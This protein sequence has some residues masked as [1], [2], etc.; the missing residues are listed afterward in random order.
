MMMKQNHTL[1]GDCVSIDQ[2]QSTTPGRHKQTRGKEKEK[3][4]GGTIF[5][6][7]ATTFTYAEHQITLSAGNTV[8]SKQNFEAELE[9]YGVIAR[10][11]RADNAPFRS[12]EFLEDIETKRQKISYSGV[13]AHHQNGIAEN[14]IGTI[15]SWARSMMIHAVLHW[16]SQA[17]VELWPMALDF[18]VYVWNHMPKKDGGLSPIELLSGQ[19]EP[20]YDHL[21]RLHTFMAPCYVLDPKLQD[22]KK[23]P[24]W[25]RR[26][27]LG[28]Y[29]GPS[30]DH[31][32]TVGQV[33]NLTT[34]NISPQ[35]HVVHDDGFTTVANP[36][37][38]N[39][40]TLQKVWLELIKS[41]H[42]KYFDPDDLIDAN[43]KLIPPPPLHDQWLTERE[44]RRRML[45]C[46]D[47]VSKSTTFR[48]G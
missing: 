45:T 39:E 19:I 14:A 21:Q 29:L 43:G 32:S 47:Y 12:K 17:D 2:Y 30:K 3:F 28:Q 46:R 48:G 20:N 36:G 42:E 5:V 23:I 24:K 9:Q 4:V 34:G 31:S 16:P 1:A 11:Y 37:V 33:L 35:Y 26:S 18:A 40:D 38:D 6:D 22:A 25:N 27:R 8:V 44:R 41:G 15:T 7:H 13:G 10:A